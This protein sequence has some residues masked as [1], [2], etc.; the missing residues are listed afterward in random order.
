[1]GSDEGGEE[2]SCWQR[3]CDMQPNLVLVFLTRLQ[4]EV[5]GEAVDC[6][7]VTGRLL[8]D[9]SKQAVVGSSVYLPQDV[10]AF[11]NTK[12]ARMAPPMIKQVARFCHRYAERV[13][14]VL[15]FRVSAAM[16][17]PTHYGEGSM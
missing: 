16:P 5:I 2:R 6:V 1:M 13:F 3:L 11:W 12:L 9:G 10:E 7:D 8:R 14:R 17:G 4:P 15:G